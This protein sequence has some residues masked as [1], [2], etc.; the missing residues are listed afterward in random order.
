[1][2][3]ETIYSLKYSLIVK[4]SHSLQTEM[5]STLAFSF[6]LV[7]AFAACMVAGAPNQRCDYASCPP[8]ACADPD[9]SRD[10]CCGDCSRSKCRLQGRVVYG[11]HFTEW[12]PSPCTRCTCS[13]SGEAICVNETCPASS[14]NCEK[15]GYRL[16][17]RSGECCP[18]CDYGV[19]ADSCQ[20]VKTHN[21]TI[22]AKTDD[23]EECTTTVTLHSCDKTIVTTKRGQ[24]V[25]IQT[26]GD[27]IINVAAHHNQKCRD[28]RRIVVK[29]AIECQI[30]TH[31]IYY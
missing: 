14:R 15:M 16:E 5:A 23:G 3:R 27:R 31:R 19:P 17:R 7:T 24:F 13:H 21:A 12:Y 11:A 30:Q 29:D 26:N 4:I 28:V 20:L 8:L 9:Y 22:T 18:R 10:H 1:M 2:H 6:L 25:C